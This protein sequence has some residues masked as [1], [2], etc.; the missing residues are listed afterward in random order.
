MLIALN[1][2]I[3][4]NPLYS[5][6]EINI[7]ALNSLPENGIPEELSNVE[8]NVSEIENDEILDAD[9]GPIFDDEDRV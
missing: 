1:W 3:A 8:S 7:E 6:L 9:Y 2:L 5:D 4:N